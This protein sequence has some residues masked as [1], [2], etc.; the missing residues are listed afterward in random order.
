[1]HIGVCEGFEFGPRKSR[2]TKESVEFNVLHASPAWLCISVGEGPP[3]SRDVAW[4]EACGLPASHDSKSGS[5]Q[6]AVTQPQ[7]LVTFGD[8]GEAC[9]SDPLQGL[10]TRVPRWANPAANRRT[11]E[12]LEG[13]HRVKPLRPLRRCLGSQLSEVVFFWYLG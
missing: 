4:K 1:M 6:I 7:S 10:L 13:R 8:S 11:F 3:G 9:S 5:R 2:L 12:A